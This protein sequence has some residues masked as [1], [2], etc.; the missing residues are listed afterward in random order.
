[1]KNCVIFRFLPFDTQSIIRSTFDVILEGVR[2]IPYESLHP[3]AIRH[4]RVEIY[5]TLKNV[6]VEILEENVPSV[7][8]TVDNR[9]P[10]DKIG[11]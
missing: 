8:L 4:M 3:K 10:Q 7:H 5:T 6:I 11:Y 9:H 1:M 2:V